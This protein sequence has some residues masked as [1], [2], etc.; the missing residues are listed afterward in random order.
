[1]TTP[2]FDLTERRRLLLKKLLEKQ[3]VEVSVPQAIPRRAETGPAPLSFGQQR[4]W[5]LHQLAPESTAYNVP[6]GVRLAGALDPRLFE[7][8]LAQVVRRHEVLRTVFPTVAGEPVQVVTD[9][10]GPALPETDLTG[11]PA[12]RSEAEAHRIASQLAHQAFDLA[13]GPLLKA[14]LLRLGPGDHVLLLA[15]HHIVSDGW[16]TGILV[17]ELAACYRRLAGEGVPPLPEL[18]IQYADF[19]AWQR[20]TLQGELL[21]AQLAFWKERLAGAATS[22]ELPTDRPRPPVQSVSGASEPL[23]VGE[24]VETRL[25]ELSQTHRA[26][27]FMTLLAALAC[28][29]YRHTHQEDLL[30]GS[31]A[32][33]RN[34]PETEGLIG[35]FVNTLVLRTDLTGDPDFPALL[36]RVRETVLA[37]DAHQDLPFEKLV[38]ALDLPRDLSASPLLQVMLAFQNSASAEEISSGLAI[39]SFGFETRATQLELHVSLAEGPQGL[40][41]FLNYRTQLFDPPTARRLARRFE[42]LLRAIAAEPGRRISQLPLIDEPERQQILLEWNDTRTAY[43][44]RLCLHHLIEEQAQRTPGA[45]AATFEDASL[46]YDE[47]NRRAN[48]LARHL[49]S[50]GCGPEARVGV[51]MERSLELMVALLGVLKAGAAYVPFDPEYPEERLSYMISDA[52]P[53]VLLTQEPLLARLPGAGVETICLDPGT[54]AGWSSGNLEEP[55][56]DRQLAYVIYTSGSTGRPKGAMVHHRAIRNRLLWMQS[57]YRLTGADTVLQKTPFSFDVSVWELFW[58]L[59][60]GA[61]LVL[62]RPGGHRDSGYLADLIARERVSV[63]HFV[64]SMLQSFLAVPDL[65][66]C[67]SLRLVVVSGEALPAETERLFAE[68]LPADLQNLYGPTEAAVDVTSWSCGRSAGRRSVPIGRPIDNVRIH[69]LS[70]ALEPV[71][72][73][74]SGELLIGGV[75]VGRGYLD[76]P[77]LTAERYVPDPFGEPGERLYRTGD[78][79]RFDHDG[80]LEFLGRI[81]HQVKVRGFRIELGEI[82]SVLAQHPAVREAVVLA[83]AE[84]AAGQTRLVA[85]IVATEAEAP[86][87]DAL[88]RFAQEKLPEH[89]LPTASVRLD[90]LP[91]T[92]NG[93]VDRRVL[94]APGSNRPDLEQ[95]YAP[96]RSPLEANLAEVWE[97]ILGIDRVGVHDNFFALGGDSMLATQVLARAQERGLSFSLQQLFQHQT[98]HELARET[99]VTGDGDRRAAAIPPFA[100][101]EAAD[102]ARIPEGIEDAY[103]LAMMQAGMLFHGELGAESSIYHNTVS[104]FLTAQYDAEKLDRAIQRLAVRHPLLRTS[105][106]LSG[107]SEPLQ[108]VHRTA[109]IPVRTDDLRHLTAE[110]QERALDAWFARETRDLFDWHQAPLLRFHVHLRGED[111]FQ[112]SWSEHHA[113]LDGWSVATMTTELAEHYTALL[114][115]D[116]DSPEPAAPA[117]LYRDFVALERRVLADEEAR[118]FWSG[119]LREG[120]VVEIGQTPAPGAERAE[121]IASLSVPLSPELSESVRRMARTA[122]IPLKS[123]LFAAHARVLSLVSGQSDLITGLV[124][125]GRLEEPD[126]ERVLGL[127]LN[128]LPLRMRLQGGRWIDLVREAFEEER[129]TLAYRR[130]PL[131]EI[132][133]ITGGRNLFNVEFTYLHYHV[134]QSFSNLGG[135]IKDMGSRTNIPT[136]FT[137]STYFLLDPIT[138]RL[139]LLLDYDVQRLQAGEMERLA[140]YYQ[141]ALTALSESPEARYEDLCL[142]AEPERRQV[143]AEWNRTEHPYPLESCLE[144]RFEAQVR[145]SPD[146]VAVTFEDERLTYREM[147]ARANRLAWYLRRL[148]VGPE[149]RVGVCLERSLDLVVA[150]YAVL[151]AG[152]AYVPLD[153]AYPADRLAFM[154]EDSRVAVLLTERRSAPPAAN[155]SVVVL[156]D[157]DRALWAG[158]SPDD[159]VSGATPDNLAYVIYTS[160]STGLPKGAMN[161]HRAICNRLLWMQDAYG[162][163]ADDCVLQKTPAS[164]DV[165]VWELFW[166]LQTGARL[167]VARPEGHKQPDYLIDLIRREEVTT[168]HFVPPMLRALLEEP[169]VERCTSLRRVFCSGEAL[170]ADLAQRFFSR[171]G[172][173][174]L[175]NLYGPTEAAVDVTFWAC[176]PGDRRRS[177]PIGHPI[178]NLRIYVL[179]PWSNPVPAGVP[180]ELSIGGVGLAR[181]YHDRPGLTAERF[182]PDPWGPEP[183]GRLYRTGDL[184][185]HLPDG[186]LEYLGRL[187]HQ[188]KLRGFRIELGEIE[189]ALEQHPAVHHA[190]V[191]LREDEPGDRRI[192]AYVVAD[193]AAA[194]AGPGE[195]ASLDGEQVEQWRMVFDRAYETGSEPEDP[196]FDL[197][198]WVSSYTGEPIPAHEMREWVDATVARILSLKPENVLEIGCGTGL[199]LTRIAPQTGRY[200]A[201]DFSATA[202]SRLREA[203]GDLP[204]LRLFERM[205]DD[206]SEI[207]AG[208]FDVVVVNSV[209][210]YFPDVEYLL[211]VIEGAATVLREGGYLFLGDLRS[212]P[213]HEAFHASVELFR[214]PASRTLAEVRRRARA[215]AAEDG[216]L[217]LSPELFTALAHRVPGVGGVRV[218]LKRGRAGHEMNRFRYDVIL[219]IGPAAG[220]GTGEPRQ[221]DWRGEGLGLE[222]LRAL[223]ARERPEALLVTGIPNSRV[224]RDVEAAGLLE[225]LPGEATVNDLLRTLGDDGGAV[226]P[227]DLAGLAEEAG[228]DADLTWAGDGGDGT[229]E[230]F[231][232]RA[233][234]PGE[235]WRTP[236]RPAAPHWADYAND[237]LRARLLSHFVPRLREDLKRRLPEPMVP[238]SFVLLDELPLSPNGKLDR[239]AL[240]A[241]EV[242]RPDRAGE[243]K[244]ARN[245]VEERLVEIWRE[246]LKLDRVG[247]HDNLFDIGGHSLLAT[248]IAVRIRETF[249]IELPLR[250]LYGA[251]T[252]AE[253]ALTVVQ[254]Q[255]ELT[256]EEDLEAL[257]AEVESMG[258]ADVQEAL[259]SGEADS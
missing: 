179:D 203:R 122:A 220:S 192:V 39:S 259:F 186:A 91:L 113:I 29:L 41:G 242:S 213:L 87:L 54:G 170:P 130:F 43:P 123:V 38:D 82:E 110:E 65:S 109:R 76:R 58:P 144:E 185:R 31:P 77:G 86:T 234:L 88:R 225:R 194:E 161:S 219:R 248:Q 107:F 187:D 138:H 33:N 95:A 173:A 166:P 62:A 81:D 233:G 73:G 175:H 108:L 64:P 232:Y 7:R 215:R 183:G 119:K 51:A 160:G 67:G 153:P 243:Y 236:D 182:V 139:F 47:L 255:A 211:R 159:P 20:D 37:A 181:G 253:L 244:A 27:T 164:F 34:R 5:F 217:V 84:G 147:N 200:W 25:R 188:V 142:L 246:V 78:L 17:R 101:L 141:A 30:I 155:G 45:V 53:Q 154:L 167:A 136:N 196:A 240:P 24:A 42:V 9:W 146:A 4:L 258:L 223:L 40:S 48:R 212:L 6:H 171:L 145:R 98:I 112:L 89:M 247:V 129:Q 111:R 251:P 44:D 115:E 8:A 114:R 63:L 132:Q 118:R 94:P 97:Q 116:G 191:L 162:L 102:R 32:A 74:V 231:L 104:I 214:A 143:L 128:S 227:E 56:D 222:A 229:S 93:K 158:E 75:N 70:P 168:I 96:P 120:T 49:R 137:L 254:R 208:S 140:G 151:K 19:A 198:G 249:R 172:T 11:L 117:S 157:E 165:S 79:A 226:D 61:R 99:A 85:Y 14:A 92:P 152:G 12:D 131:A 127:F 3:G 169:G 18:P 135:G 126:G 156:L 202:I 22:L 68:R 228:Y 35:F 210:Q 15:M 256:D 52:R 235:R 124:A 134:M 189:A 105:F 177:V 250:I 150:L 163:G 180:G 224:H 207:P 121:R 238:S 36:A 201:T 206:F 148:G 195:G 257:L 10:S 230:A 205:A 178:S 72:L 46:T 69:L 71:P 21:D 237:P 100:L 221:V 252:V 26:T 55:G 174:G 83:R 218:L 199:L 241:P 16:S 204:G 125:H 57:A 216:E 149:A 184:A 60:A 23:G 28:L 59:L 106:D 245:P 239:R 66:E 1:M 103:P 80:A 193:P 13:R 176:E 209:A 133:R 90:A 190:A 2:A 50:L 197:A